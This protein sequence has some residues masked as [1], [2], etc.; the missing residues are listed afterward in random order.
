V[1]ALAA[2]SLVVGCAGSGS[3]P[4][5]WSHAPG[6]AP[7]QPPAAPGTACTS[8]TVRQQACG[9][10]C[11]TQYATCIGGSWSAWS[12]CQ[13]GGE[14]EVGAV[15][16]Q[17]CGSAV[18]ACVPGT[19]QRTCLA[20]CS[21]GAWGACGGAYVGP[22]AEICG[23]GID[24]DCN[25]LVDD[26]CDGVVVAPVFKMVGDAARGLLYVLTDGA[27]ADV[28]VYDGRTRSEVARIRLPAFGSDMD[29]S[30][31][32][33]RLVVAHDVSN[34]IS[35]VDLAA[36][37]VST[38]VAVSSDPCRIEVSDAGLVYYVELSQWT[39]VRRVDPAAGP[40]SDTLLTQYTVYEGDLELAPDGR[41]LYTGEAWLSGSNLVRWDVSGGGFVQADRSTWNDGYGFPYPARR[42][43]LSA[44]GA[45]VY[46]AQHQL[47]ARNL[48]TVLGST[49]ETVF[50]EDPAGTWAVGERSVFD[51]RTLRRLGGLPQVAGDAA[52]A[53]S[54]VFAWYAPSKGK[55]YW[56]DATVFGGPATLGSRVLDPEPLGSSTLSR[57]ARDPAR[58]RLYG[59]DATRNPVVSIDVPG[60]GTITKVDLGAY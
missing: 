15:Q 21:W 53:T 18:G 3:D 43:R 14:C 34:Q 4:D 44:D 1:A 28:T 39:A 7:D 56:G 54:T 50:A 35:V 29:L 2:V 59:L 48:A 8:G 55:L 57:L 27:T 5:V 33:T 13:D 17:A 49:G 9:T 40:G 51:A 6:A 36:A 16:S 45:R 38:T 19:Q 41:S 12:A 22:V 25:G 37:S 11:G 10:R 46:Y 24:D 60:A 31:D 20:S 58:E 42:V 32:G 26:D 52:F 47:D 23:N 30:P